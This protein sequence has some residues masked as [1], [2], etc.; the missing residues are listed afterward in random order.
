MSRANL[1]PTPSSFRPANRFPGQTRINV[2]PTPAPH[3]SQTKTIN[4]GPSQYFCANFQK[5][6]CLKESPHPGMIKGTEVMLQHICAKCL[7]HGK[8]TTYHPETSPQ[9]PLAWPKITQVSYPQVRLNAQLALPQVIR[10][11]TLIKASGRPNY[12]GLCIPHPSKFDLKF[13]DDH[14]THHE[15]RFIVECLKFGCPIGLNRDNVLTQ[16]PVSNHKGAMQHPTA[17][18]TLNTVDKRNSIDRRVIVDLS[19]PKWANSVNNAIDLGG[20]HSWCRCYL[21][22]SHNRCL[23]GVG[24]WERQGLC[25]F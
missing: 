22:V 19:Y 25:A 6:R 10:A 4:Q 11:N 2:G 3:S 16:L 17:I 21:K 13:L 24:C 7:L 18:D 14:L 23:N 15:D 20:C 12:A 1:K 8:K 9:C 5:G